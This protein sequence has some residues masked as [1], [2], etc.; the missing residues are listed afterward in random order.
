MSRF[1]SSLGLGVLALCLTAAA[2]DTFSRE[3]LEALEAE[4]K[5]AVEK[6]EALQAAGENTETDIR[7]IEENLISAAM[8][9]QRREEEAALTELSL[10]NLAVRR[11]AAQEELLRDREALQDLLGALATSNRRQPPALVVSPGKSNTAIRRAILMSDTMPRLKSRADALSGEINE[12][13]MLER[14]IRGERMRLEAAEA[15][16][17]LK[18][19]EIERLAA[20]KRAT[21]EDLSGD[22]AMLQNRAAELGEQAGSLR[23]LLE[24]LEANA[25]SVPSGKPALRPR[26]ASAT[27]LTKAP[28]SGASSPRISRRPATGKPLGAAALG[29]LR[30]PVAGQLVHGFGDKLPTGGKS[31]WLTFSTRSEAQVT[32]PVNGTVEYARPFR[33]YRAMLILR[34]SDEY[35]VILTGMSKIYVTE[36]QEVS[37]GEPVG[38]MPDRAQPAPELSM[39]LRNGDEVLN[40][41]KWMPGGRR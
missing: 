12:L 2:P 20:A 17:S 34:T 18:K 1:F 16:L 37:V 4:R 10:V 21:Y 39:E 38:R 6:L 5:A 14:R 7:K 41:A 28:Q 15:T 29:G 30:Q 11:D 40:P 36:G 27:P 3:E 23:E 33:S 22:I 25:P 8:E 13:N 9:S 19:L 35:H 31:E 32:A 24:G 26:L